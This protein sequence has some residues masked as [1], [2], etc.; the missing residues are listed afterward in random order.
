MADNT[1]SWGRSILE[2][3]AY[4][5]VVLAIG[6][7]VATA[8]TPALVAAW[9]NNSPVP[10]VYKMTKRQATAALESAGFRHLAYVDVCS[11]SVAAGE[12]REVLVDNSAPVED[13]ISLVNKQTNERPFPL[14]ISQDTPLVV[15]VGTGQPCG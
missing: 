15:K 9:D 13:E 4:P 1:K 3:I 5:V 2:G 12:V 8:V 6:V 14:D 11:G 7:L 10:D